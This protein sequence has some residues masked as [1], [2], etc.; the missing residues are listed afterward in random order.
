MAKITRHGGASNRAAGTTVPEPTTEATPS[1]VELVLPDAVDE[2]RESSG[3]GVA[4][5]GVEAPADGT[6]HELVVYPYDG[7]LRNDLQELCRTRGLPT[8]GNKDEM[9]ARLA[10]AD[11][12]QDSDPA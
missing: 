4:T 10:A 6:E 11:E 7:M 5:E 1:V 3:T 12:E 9:I 2:E 8:S